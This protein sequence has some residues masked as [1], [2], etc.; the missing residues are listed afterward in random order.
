M[1]KIIFAAKGWKA[2][3]KD[4]VSQDLHSMHLQ[5][6]HTYLQKDVTNFS[7]EEMIIHYGFISH[8]AMQASIANY[9]QTGT[10]D[11]SEYFF[12]LAAKAKETSICLW[13]A[14]PH[15]QAQQGQEVQL[16]CLMA[17]ILSGCTSS[18]IDMLE[19]TRMSLEQEQQQAN[20][21]RKDLQQSE[22]R[23][24]RISLEIDLYEGLLKNDDE[25]AS[26]LLPE[27]NELHQDPLMLQVM[28]TF[29]EQDN[30]QFMDA[31]IQHMKEFRSTPYPKE[32]NYFVLVMEALY[33]KRKRYDPLDFADAPALLLK[34]P[35]CNP[36]LLEE[37]IGLHLPSFAVNDLLKVLDTDKIGPK[38]MQY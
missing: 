35:E 34:L 33:Q 25:Q 9:M 38:F 5:K 8:A 32:L 21:S 4:Y 19:K 17:A 1:K 2:L 31:L 36:V 7:F 6:L 15:K 37:K 26:R 27:L 13:T 29:F 10:F 3:Q 20:K 18:A 28:R 30:E 16:D 22:K 11:N 24:K 14:N 23:K 12:Y